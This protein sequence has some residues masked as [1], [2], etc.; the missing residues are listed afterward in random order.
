M[1]VY[2]ATIITVF[3]R[4]EENSIPPNKPILL[5]YEAFSKAPLSFLLFCLSVFVRV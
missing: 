1:D 2:S 4:L 3:I 5:W